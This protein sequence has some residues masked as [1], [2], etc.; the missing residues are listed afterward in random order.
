MGKKSLSNIHQHCLQ[1]NIH[2]KNIKIYKHKLSK[3]S[4]NCITNQYDSLFTNDVQFA[5][6]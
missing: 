1:I 5:Y 4:D 3:I 6:K 2:L